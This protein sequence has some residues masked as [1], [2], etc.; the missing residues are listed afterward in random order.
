M[1][2]WENAFK[3]AGLTVLY[4]IVWMIVGYFL[5]SL[6]AR[7]PSAIGLAIELAGVVIFCLGFLASFYKIGGEL[8]AE[9]VT[10]KGRPIPE[11]P[12][13]GNPCPTCG[14]LNPEGLSFCGSCGTRLR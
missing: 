5:L 3:G 13:V 14:A 8:I 10:S 4:T 1:V 7:L 6:G 12:K 2:T 11:P 9:E